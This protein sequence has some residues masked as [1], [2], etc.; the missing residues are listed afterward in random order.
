MSKKFE[1]LT[2]S[3]CLTD[4]IE[5]AKKGHSS[6]NRAKNGKAYVNI[7]IFVNEE[8]DTYGNHAQILLNPKKD[9]EDYKIYI[10]NLKKNEFTSQGTSEKPTMTNAEIITEYEEKLP[11]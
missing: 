2:G 10:G 9:A 3:I 7:K 1:L 8:A 11:F 4:L 5:Q 6:I